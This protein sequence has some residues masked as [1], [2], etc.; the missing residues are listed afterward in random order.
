[1]RMRLRFRSLGLA[2]LSVAAA[3][4]LLQLGQGQASSKKAR[5]PTASATKQQALAAYGKLPLAFTANAGQTDAR[6]RYSA[7]GAG[8]SVF[9]TRREAMLS[10]RVRA[11]SEEGAAWRSRSA[12]SARTGTSPSAASARGRAG[13]TTCSETI[14]PSGAPACA[15]SSASSTATSGRAWT[16]SSRGRTGTLKYEFLVRPGARVS[17]HQAR[18]PRREA[19]LARPAGKPAHPHLA[20]RPHRHA[21]AQLPARRWQARARRKRV[22]TRP[23]RRLRLRP[24]PATTAATRSS[25]TRGSS[26]PP[27]WA[28]AGHDAGFDIAVDA[29]GR[30]T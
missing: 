11:S 24:R 14:P 3:G 6:V 5:R 29:A 9:L 23:A 20:R 15:P 30:P 12:S 19:A 28:E 1:M 17:R 2:L 7:Q 16:W 8:F 13:S 21:A 10:L 25:S 22:R 4:V 26:T 18:L 27:T